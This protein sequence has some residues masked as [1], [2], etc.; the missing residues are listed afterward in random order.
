MMVRNCDN[1]AFFEVTFDFADADCQQA[2]AVLDQSQFRA[3]VDTNGSFRAGSE[4]NPALASRSGL[5]FCQN[6]S[7][8]I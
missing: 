3:F 6:Q 5:A 4:S 1:I 8:H 2:P 7:A